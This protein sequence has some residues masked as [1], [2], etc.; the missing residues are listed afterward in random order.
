M[1]TEIQKFKGDN[2]NTKDK[3]AERLD[4]NLKSGQR[5]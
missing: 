5:R 3:Y 1:K 2:Y 4:K